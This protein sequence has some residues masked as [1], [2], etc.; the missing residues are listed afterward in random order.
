MMERSE[1]YLDYAVPFAVIADDLS[2]IFRSRKFRAAQATES[3]LLENAILVAGKM[4]S[5]EADNACNREYGI[6]CCR[7]GVTTDGRCVCCVYLDDCGACNGYDLEKH[8]HDLCGPI[9]NIAN[10]LQVMKEHIAD[11]EIGKISEYVEFALNSVHA[12]HKLNEQILSGGNSSAVDLAAVIDNIRRLLSTQLT[13]AGCTISVDSSIPPVR[14]DYA[15]V[16]R[17]L[18]NLIENSLRHS[19][20]GPLAMSL[21]LLYRTPEAVAILLE[22]T[23]ADVPRETREA[24]NGVLRSRCTPDGFLGLRICKELMDGMHGDIQI[25]MEKP[26][27]CYRLTFKTHERR[28]LT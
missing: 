7:V 25:V 26:S 4:L 20:T 27:C 13:M 8:H 24:I 5:D 14:G 10:F 28:E 23:G 17:V 11:A 1:Q 16:L 15:S 3:D 6:G 2:V 21:K 12:L 9:R 19:E 22:D 18:K